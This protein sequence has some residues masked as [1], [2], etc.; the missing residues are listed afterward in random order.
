MTEYFEKKECQFGSGLIAMRPIPAGTILFGVNDWQDE[1]EKNSFTVLVPEEIDALDTERRSLFLR[2]AY[3][4]DPLR[5]EG[6][7]RHAEVRHPCNF[8]NHSCAGNL[9]YDGLDHIVALTDI[10]RGEALTMDYA[11]YTFSFDHEFAC[12][13]ATPHCRGRVTRED[14]KEQIGRRAFGF[15]SFMHDQ[16]RERLKSQSRPESVKRVAS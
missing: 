1:H 8:I 6:T 13:C 2:F 12:H 4:V 9:G 15:P 7:F 10:G 16:I 14:W 11:T 5:I 3:N